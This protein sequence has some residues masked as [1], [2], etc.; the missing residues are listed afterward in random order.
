MTNSTGTQ[1]FDPWTKI[2]ANEFRERQGR[3][4]QAAADQ[5]FAGAVVWS[6]GGAFMDMAQ[7]VLYLTSHYSQQPY[8]GDEAGIGTARSHG[9]CILPVDGPTT[10]VVDVPWWRKDLVVADDVRA[11]IDVAGTAA[12]AIQDL[13]LAEKRLAL[14]GASYMTAAAYLELIGRLPGTELIRSDRMV[15]AIRMMKSP[16]E[17]EIIREAAK[18]GSR[19]MDAM[20]SAVVPGATE[21][22]AVSE[23][24]RVLLAG[25]GVLYDAACG[26]GPHA[27]QYT[28]ARLPSADPLRRLESGD[29]FHV[30]FY[31]SYGGYFFDFAR[32]RVVGDAPVEPQKDLV[33]ATIECVETICHGIRPGM[34][35]GELYAVG[36]K[37]MAGSRTV[38]SIPAELP[39]MEGFPAFGHGIGMMWEMPWIM[40]ND[41]TVLRPGM[42]LGIEV[43]LG[44]RGVGGAMFEEDGVVTESGFEILTDA[45]RRWW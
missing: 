10:V 36:S 33:E 8:M 5:G 3:V 9:V 17:I 37:W 25:G 43:L 15:E 42:Y 34:T 24:T 30:D 44:H 26:S 19:S 21:A 41:P 12:R 22:E 18:L 16:A 45:R 29:M 4:R 28:H 11:S 6:R 1:S 7:D 2:S 31:G 20:L 38:A 14:V 40:P 23:A 13:G 39:E 27:H 32:S 35:A